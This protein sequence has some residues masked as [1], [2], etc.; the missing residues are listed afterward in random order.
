MK[1]IT[2]ENKNPEGNY[3]LLSG[4]MKKRKIGYWTFKNEDLLK[5]VKLEVKPNISI[6]KVQ[7]NPNEK[8]LILASCYLTESKQYFFCNEEIGR[9]IPSLGMSIRGDPLA[10]NEIICFGTTFGSIFSLALDNTDE[11]LENPIINGKSLISTYRAFSLL[12][13]SKKI[14]TEKEWSYSHAGT[15]AG[16]IEI[17]DSASSI[18]WSKIYSNFFEN[19][20]NLDQKLRDRIIKK[21][22]IQKEELDQILNLHP[23]DDSGQEIKESDLVKLVLK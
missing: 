14:P 10:G 21:T 22:K 3:L 20:F 12:D 16:Q 2:L 13:K 1:R 9:Y 15:W 18:I 11:N 19:N 5:P 8:E 23:K 4:E 7:F 17:H 6:R